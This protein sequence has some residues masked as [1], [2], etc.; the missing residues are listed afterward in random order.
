MV[1]SVGDAIGN[2]E[3]LG[4]SMV[5]GRQIKFAVTMGRSSVPEIKE[6]FLSSAKT[7]PNRNRATTPAETRRTGIDRRWIPSQD[8]QPERRRGKDRRANRTRSFTDPLVVNE[9]EKHADAGND[10]GTASFRIGGL[11]PSVPD[12]AGRTTLPDGETTE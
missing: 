10:I 5:R 4:G 3:P 6:H 7:N 8:H 1:L 9:T 11:H 2:E 12:D